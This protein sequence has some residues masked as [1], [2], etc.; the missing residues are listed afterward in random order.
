LFPDI[1]GRKKKVLLCCTLAPSFLATNKKQNLL[2]AMAT[3][4]KPD[5]TVADYADVSDHEKQIM[6][7]DDERTFE[8]DV[9]ALPPGYFKS[10]NFI[11][12]MFAAQSAWAA[13]SFFASSLPFSLFWQHEK[14]TRKN[15]RALE[16]SLSQ[17]RCWV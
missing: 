13:V 17:R 7:S 14:L 2:E 5:L 10:L 8:T 3:T 16:V 11:G 6:D 9:E 4:T 15:S 1:L 12:T